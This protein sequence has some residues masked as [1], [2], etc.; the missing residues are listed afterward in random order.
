MNRGTD[1]I[2]IHLS[3]QAHRWLNRL[4]E[5]GYRRTRP[6]KAVVSVL[7]DSHYVLGPQTVFEQARELY[8]KLGLVTVYRTIE[9]LEALGLIQRV[10]QP[11]GCQGFIAA[12]TGHQHL[13]ICQECGLAEYF[14]G[15]HESIDILMTEI[16]RKSHYQIKEHWLQ[17]LGICSR[18]QKAVTSN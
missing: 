8:P 5:N 2:N 17:L 9:K 14:D 10:H 7:A 15:D 1:F 3:E 12:F 18:C 13:L 11:A 16:E 6:R 4:H